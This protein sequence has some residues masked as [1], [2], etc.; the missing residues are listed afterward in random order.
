MRTDRRRSV[1]RLATAVFSVVAV[2]GCAVTGRYDPSFAEGTDDT[3]VTLPAPH[4]TQELPLIV[5]RAWGESTEMLAALTM[6]AYSIFPPEARARRR[7]PVRVVP[8][9]AVA[10]PEGSSPI[11]LFHRGELLIVL[12]TEST[13]WSQYVYQVSHEL[14]H[15]LL[16]SPAVDDI[17]TWNVLMDVPNKWIDETLCQIASYQAL[18]KVAEMWERHPP[19]RAARRHAT[20]FRSYIEGEL[21]R[22]ESVPKNKSFEEWLA[23]HIVY[24]SDHPYDRPKNKVVA[25]QLL[26]LFQSRPSLWTCATHL[27]V[28]RTSS[29]APDIR[30]LLENWKAHAPESCRDDINT[31]Q[32]TVGF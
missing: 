14:C 25:H 22:A 29:A 31:F 19:F 27:N 5:D 9:K 17:Q 12:D 21:K 30:S 20:I 28:N 15:A 2:A 10:F 16:L 18:P 3:A 26:P 24:L 32:S 7:H 1:S 23:G 13:R 8:R 6:A 4:A 11:T